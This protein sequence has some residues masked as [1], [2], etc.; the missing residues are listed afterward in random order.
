MFGFQN[1]TTIILAGA[2]GCGKTT[3]LKKLLEKQDEMFKE[4]PQKVLYF[5]GVWQPMFEEMENAGVEFI[6]GLPPADLENTTGQPLL[7]VLDDLQEQ[8]TKSD[9]VESLF[10]KGS[11]HQNM[12]VIYLTQNLFRQGKN[13]RNIGLNAHYFVLFKNPRDIGQIGYLGRQLGCCN[14][15][16]RAFQDATEEKYGYLV[17]DLNPHSEDQYRY[18][19]HIWPGEDTIV[20]KP[21]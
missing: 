15:L 16:K 17:I 20:Y 12:T 3:W 14:F 7:V 2:T 19:T 5:Y 18:R 9:S 4:P 10:T 11:H 13:A 1:P 6:K 8:A 21:L